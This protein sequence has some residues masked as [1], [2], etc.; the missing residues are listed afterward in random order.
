MVSKPLVCA[1]FEPPSE[2]GL[3]PDVWFL[4]EVEQLLGELLA[5][6]ECGAPRR[7]Y[8]SAVDGAGARAV[9]RVLGLA[10]RVLEEPRPA[11]DRALLRS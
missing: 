7:A 8:A 11:L 2:R 5:D 6:L 4:G 1:C 10:A 3:E 9:R